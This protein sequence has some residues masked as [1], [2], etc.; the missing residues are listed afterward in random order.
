M[1]VGMNTN[2]FELE[3]DKRI[4]LTIPYALQMECGSKS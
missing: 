2:I 3:N 4:D 1:R